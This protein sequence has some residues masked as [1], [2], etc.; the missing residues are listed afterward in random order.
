MKNESFESLNEQS[1]EE[2]IKEISFQQNQHQHKR[3][4]KAVPQSWKAFLWCTLCGDHTKKRGVRH[5]F[6]KTLAELDG[7]GGAYHVNTCRDMKVYK[8]NSRGV[9][10]LC[11]KRDKFLWFSPSKWKQHV[12][13]AMHAVDKFLFRS[14]HSPKTLVHGSFPK[15]GFVALNLQYKNIKAGYGSYHWTHQQKWMVVT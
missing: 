3:R 2:N 14:P 5:I 11:P 8:T 10:V 4:N 1:I 7:H 6:G 9:P 15:R 13:S 12:C